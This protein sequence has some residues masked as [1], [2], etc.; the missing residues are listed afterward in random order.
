RGAKT[1][2]RILGYGRRAEHVEPGSSLSG[3]AIAQAIQGALAMGHVAPNEVGHV[4]AHGL[5]TVDDD[6]IEARA[7]LETLGEVPVTAMKGYVG[8][9]GASCGA[10]ELALSLLAMERNLIPPALNCDDPA[11]DLNIATKMRFA[12]SPA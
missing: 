7:I 8:S 10:V 12:S 6:A 1:R 5:G 3:Q 2:G 9:S 4:N 11:F